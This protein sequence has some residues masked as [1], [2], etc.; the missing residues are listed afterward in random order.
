MVTFDPHY[1][2][3]RKMDDLALANPVGRGEG[4][5]GGVALVV[6]TVTAAVFHPTGATTSWYLNSELDNLTE[7][8]AVVMV[9]N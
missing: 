2:P 5:G 9:T 1:P 8:T 3:A 7:T 6:V 4:G